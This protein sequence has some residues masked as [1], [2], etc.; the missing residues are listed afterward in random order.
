MED[1]T[2]KQ[3]I[4]AHRG[5][6][7]DLGLREKLAGRLP[8]K[9]GASY[10][11]S[12][13]CKECHQEDYEIWEETLHA[14]AWKTLEKAEVDPDRYKW[15]V[16]HYPD[17]V[18]CHVVGYY[19]KTGF[20]NPEKTPDLAGV[21]CEE[22]HGAASEHVKDPKKHKL[23]PVHPTKCTKCHDFE[24]TPDFDYNDYWQMIEHGK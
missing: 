6:V 13:A 20:I 17:C 4:L 2:A 21:G 22:C 3:V 18:Y 1:K 19:Q 14:E 7:K 11:G 16:T 23:G 10:V 24:Q 9:N 8:T 5:T 12:S 15:P